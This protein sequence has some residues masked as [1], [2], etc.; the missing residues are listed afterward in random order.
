[1]QFQ[2]WG[3]KIP[4]HNDFEEVNLRFYVKYKDVDE[5]K[6]GV[7]F[8]KEVVPKRAL[9]IIAGSIYKENYVTNPMNHL[10]EEGESERTVQYQWYCNKKWQRIKVMAKMEPTEILEGS[11]AEFITEHYWGYTRVSPSRTY[12][13][14]VTHPRWQKYDALGHEISI[15]FGQVYGPEFASLNHQ[16]P[17]SVF[18]AEGSPIAVKSKR[19]INPS[20]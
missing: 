19:E 18:L 17:V 14:E 2:G 9:S 11:E 5:W 16:Q 13:Y 15:D 8:I 7:V 4:Y 20:T 1:V 12:E 6:R 3:I 10:W